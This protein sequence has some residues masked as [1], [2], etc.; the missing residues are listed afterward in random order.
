MPYVHTAPR[1]HVVLRNPTDLTE[2]L[3]DDVIKSVP[4]VADR[5]NAELRA[6]GYDQFCVNAPTLYQI[7]R[8]CAYKCS[9]KTISAVDY[10]SLSRLTPVTPPPVVTRPPTTQPPDQPDPPAPTATLG[11]TPQSSADGVPHDE[12][13]VSPRSASQS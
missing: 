8:G 1:W 10:V 3:L 7:S 13:P 5:F 9:K 4:L 2:V 6:R 12:A 11:S